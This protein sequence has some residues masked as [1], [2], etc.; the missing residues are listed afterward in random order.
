M[1]LAAEDTP[2][3]RRRPPPA[4]E[5]A[6]RERPSEADYRKRST[7]A[8]SPARGASYAAGFAL[9]FATGLI[10]NLAAPRAAAP[11]PSARPSRTTRPSRPAMRA[12]PPVR[13]R[14]GAPPPRPQAKGPQ[15]KGQAKLA[16]PPAAGPFGAVLNWLR[17]K[18]DA[19]R[20]W[21]EGLIA[22]FSKRGDGVFEYALVTL[23][24]WGLTI[25][26]GAIR[27]LILFQVYL[28]G[29]SAMQIASLFLFYEVFGVLTNLFGG[30]I[31]ANFGLRVTLFGG[32][33][34]QVAALGML[35][36]LNPA[37]PTWLVIGYVMVSQALSGIAKDLT[38]MS[39]KSAIKA[40]VP[41]DADATMYRWVSLLTGSK[42]ALKGVGFFVGALLLTVAGFNLSLLIMAGGLLFT[43]TALWRHLPDDLGRTKQKAKFTSMFSMDR[44][45][46]ILSAARFF[47]FGARDVWF[48]VALPVYL[49]AVFGWSPMVVGAYLALWTI[50]Y[51]IVQS[52]APKFIAAKPGEAPK[53]YTV[54]LWSAILT[55]VP[56]AIALGAGVFPGFSLVAGLAAFGVVFAINSAVHS[57]MI[58]HYA[59]SEK[60]AMTIGFYYMANAGGRLAGTVLSGLVYQYAGGIVACLWLSAVF[61]GSAALISTGLILPEERRALGP[62]KANK[63]ALAP[64]PA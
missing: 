33:G 30:W 1:S 3:R 25:T 11:A 55:A 26:D 61:V 16:A 29:Y 17:R 27:M 39:S 13:R 52:L 42:N 2:Y 44:R 60:V 12:H 20:A 50:G 46:N 22:T 45:I 23:A 43:L 4:G 58:V 9:S 35:A 62:P 21:L 34:I 38:K 18:R 64:L 57:Y 5:P 15:A 7:S 6:A 28:M 14:P 53:G 48:V 54:F 41:K 8:R 37:W 31:G 56:V 24:Y 19:W 47:L 40:V 63:G 10:R 36:L 32:L 51:G 49:A 59:E